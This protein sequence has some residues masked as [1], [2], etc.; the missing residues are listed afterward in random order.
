MTTREPRWTEQDRAE[1]LALAMYRDG[2]CPLCGRP[3]RICTTPE[4]SGPQYEV[5]WQVCG[6]TRTKL[7]YQRGVY[8]ADAKHPNREAHVW[9]TRIREG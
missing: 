8:T 7:E 6:A 4:E 5:I 9:G 3:L 1:L 2:L